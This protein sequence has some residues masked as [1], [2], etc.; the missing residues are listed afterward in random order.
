MVRLT[1]ASDPDE[2]LDSV[3]LPNPTAG[4]V[5]ATERNGTISLAQHEPAD[6]TTPANLRTWMLRVQNGKRW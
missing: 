4:I 5:A 3:A 1:K 6:G 2:V